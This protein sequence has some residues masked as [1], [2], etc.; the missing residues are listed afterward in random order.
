MAKNIVNLSLDG[1]NYTTRPYGT[2]DTAAGTAAKAVTCADFSL[3]TGATIL[4]KFTNANSVSSP[5]LNVN[6]TGAKSI[7]YRGAALT[8]SLYYWGAGDIVEFYYNGT[9]WNLLDV[10]NTNTNTDTKVKQSSSTSSANLPILTAT[11]S[12]LAI[13]LSTN[14]CLSNGEHLARIFN[15]FKI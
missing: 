4:V 6:S 12:S 11:T 1:S 8:S 15:L 9:Q 10:S 3:A 14:L 5:T 2:C 7:Y 13:N